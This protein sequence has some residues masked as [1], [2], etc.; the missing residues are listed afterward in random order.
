MYVDVGTTLAR[1]PTSAAM[2]AS[3]A[4]ILLRSGVQIGGSQQRRDPAAPVNSLCVELSEASLQE[5]VPSTPTSGASG[6]EY[7]RPEA[8]GMQADMKRTGRPQNRHTRGQNRTGRWLDQ[9]LQRALAT[10]EA[11]GK[12]KTVARYYNIPSNSLSNHLYGRTLT[13]KEG[14]PTILTAAEESALT[15]YMNKMQDFGHPLSMQQLRMKVAMI[16]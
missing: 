8:S 10:V 12:I 4:G 15:A 7:G 14:P 16:T 13:H 5:D 1:Q 3:Q 11:G 6:A 2:G 9:T